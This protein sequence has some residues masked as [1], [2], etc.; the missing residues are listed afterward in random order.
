MT[1]TL[2]DGGFNDITAGR[3]GLFIFHRGDQ[4]VGRSLRKYGEFSP[5]E[6]QL[7]RQIIHNGE[8]IVE[9]GANFGA[10]TVE[11]SRLVGRAGTVH[12]FEPQRLVFQTLCANLALN[13]CANVFAHQAAVGVEV[14]EILVPAIP[15]ERGANFGGVTLT[16][17]TAGERVPLRTID[18]L[19]LAACHAMKVDVEG[20]EVEALRGA[21]D[22]IRAHRPLLYVEN[23]REARSPE[24]IALLLSWNYDLYWHLPPLFD[25]GNFAADPE[26]IFPGI[27]SIN[28]LGV[29]TERGLTVE[30]STRITRPEDKWNAAP[31]G[32]GAS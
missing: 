8:T 31:V 14:G 29:P 11:L 25:A 30:G 17:V 20:M 4:Y 5:G 21:A 27:V 26:N 28:V 19:G 23:D 13:S 7:F 1:P 3:H 16:G 22:T 6:S 9:A 32:A 15:P 18:G 2:P 12:A 10:H 24:L